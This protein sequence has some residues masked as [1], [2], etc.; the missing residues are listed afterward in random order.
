MPPLSDYRL[1]RRKIVAWDTNPPAPFAGFGGTVGLGQD[2]AELSN[3]DW[4][5]VFHAGYWHVSMATPFVVPDDALTRWAGRGF[6]RDIRAP[7][8]GRILGIR[9][10]DRGATWSK[11]FDILVNDGDVSPVGINRISDG[12][13]LVFVNNQA[14]WY[15]LDQAPPGHSPVNTRIGV[16]RS[17]DE[18]R[19]WSPPVWL[20]MPYPYYQRAYAQSIEL[21]DG[22]LLY[23]TYSAA[24]R[25]AP[26][27]G[28]IHRS[29][30]GGRT[31]ALLS[32]IERTDGGSVD[33][34]S[35]VQLRD[36][37]LML[38]TRPDAAIFYSQDNGKSWTMSHHAP[39]LAPLK[40]SRLC[41]LHDGTIVC[42]A[43]SHERLCATFSTDGGETWHVNREG[44]P[45]ALDPDHYGYPGGFSD[46]DG[47][48]TCVY[49]DAANQQR[50]T[51]VWLVRF[52]VNARRTGIDLLAAATAPQPPAPADK[53]DRTESLPESSTKQHEELDVEAM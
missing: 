27:H 4:L 50:R 38:I 5:V 16:I 40:A 34:P 45:P 35:I 11:P 24:T 20:D 6:P 2:I 1:Q 26:L 36:G 13:L 19:T 7:Q 48:I 3:G 12:S 21:S 49:Y 33:E 46:A 25:T 52:R 9:S 10:S 15:G 42:W 23:P 17:N 30:D 28:A 37:R 8:G 39:A 31:W 14:S 41:C 29:T 44:L 47:N 32:R 43:T 18:G 53:S 22:S 51:G